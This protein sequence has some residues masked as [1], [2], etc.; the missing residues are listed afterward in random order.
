MN[1]PILVH[2]PAVIMLTFT[3]L[4]LCSAVSKKNDIIYRNSFSGGILA[5]FK[6]ILVPPICMRRRIIV[7]GSQLAGPNPVYFCFQ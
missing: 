1:L 2:V 6:F 4:L 3:L 7:P 5:F